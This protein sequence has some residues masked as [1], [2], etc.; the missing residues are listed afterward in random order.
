MTHP[1]VSWFVVQA[2][3][4]CHS[5]VPWTVVDGSMEVWGKDGQPDTV[6]DVIRAVCDAYGAKNR[7]VTA[8]ALC[9]A[10]PRRGGR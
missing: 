5:F 10:R 3:C 4:G 1:R 8:P 7:R 2:P 6:D 9:A